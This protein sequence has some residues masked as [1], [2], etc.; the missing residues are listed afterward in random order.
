MKL[1]DNLFLD[2]SG[3]VL[4]VAGVK[5]EWTGY[6]AA[7][8]V[9]TYTPNPDAVPGRNGVTLALEHAERVAKILTDAYPKLKGHLSIKT[10]DEVS[11]FT[12]GGT[13]TELGNGRDVFGH[14]AWWICYQDRAAF[15][16][17]AIAMAGLNGRIDL[18][19]ELQS[20]GL[21]AELK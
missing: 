6:M 16:P 5:T 8:T 20:N 9:S 10:S 13:I 18:D 11:G 12:G 15:H 3:K 4:R 14:S 1:R 19:A 17:F 7:S 2:V 21:L